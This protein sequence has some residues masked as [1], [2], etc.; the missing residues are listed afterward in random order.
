MKK[1]FLSAIYLLMFQ[2]SFAQDSSQILEIDNLVTLNETKVASTFEKT[3]KNK[4]WSSHGRNPDKIS[5]VYRFADNNILIST[6]YTA[7]S[8]GDTDMII[9]FYFD[10]DH[11]IKAKT[12][13][14]DINNKRIETNYY[15][16]NNQLIN[17]EVE[18]SG[19]HG[20]NYYVERAIRIR[21]ELKKRPIKVP[22]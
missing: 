14:F 20:A 12:A 8:I 6:T 11:L 21:K 4:T 19:I 7:Y 18:M 15:Y 5:N 9:N 3:E 16:S 10:S 2:T 1:H 13:Y 22:S 17:K